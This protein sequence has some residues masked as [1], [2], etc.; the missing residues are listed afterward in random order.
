M[1]ST[2]RLFAPALGLLF[3]A[4][5]A[6]GQEPR[7]RPPAGSPANAGAPVTISADRMEG[8]ANKETSASGNAELRQ[9]NVS[10]QADRLLY[11]YATDEVQATGGVRLARDGDRLS[12]TGLRLRVRDSV[13]QFDHADYAFSLRARA[14]YSPVQ[15]R[16]TAT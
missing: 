1:K 10:I 5:L 12:G 13:G 9:D 11:I 7:L 4:A 16:G 14:G 3:C 8:Y 6:Q 15:A 2:M